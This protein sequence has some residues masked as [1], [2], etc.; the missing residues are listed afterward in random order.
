MK[1]YLFFLLLMLTCSC[2]KDKD[3]RRLTFALDFAGDNRKELEIVLD[4]Y[5]DDSLKLA[6]AKFLIRNMSFYYSFKSTQ[7]ENYKQNL[8]SI[9][10]ENNCSAAEAY[11]IASER[12][13][14][15]SFANF[16]IVYDSH[17]ITADYLIRNIDLAFKVW[18]EVPW[19][20]CI[21][22][23]EFCENILPYRIKD[24][25]LEDWR[26]E[27]YYLYQPLLDSLGAKEDPVKACQVI[28]DHI[29]KQNWVF[30]YDTQLPHLGGLT[31][32]NNRF[33]NCRDRCDLSVYIMRALGISG[34]IDYILQHPDRLHKGHSWNYVKN[35]IGDNVVFELYDL[36]PDSVQDPGSKIKKGIVYRNCFGIQENTLTLVSDKADIPMS[37]SSAFMKDVS[38]L[39]FD[40]VNVV[41]DNLKKKTIVYLAVFNN[42]EWVPVAWNKTEDSKVEFNYLERNIAYI[43]GEYKYSKFIP[44][45]Y[46]FILRENGETEFLKPDILHKQNMILTRKHP[47]PKWWFWFKD[48]T[49]NGKFQGANRCDFKDA[50][51]LYTLTHEATM[52]NYIIEIEEQKKFKYLRY[53]SGINGGCNMAEVNFYTDD[54]EIPIKGKVIGTEG[55]FQNDPQRTKFAMFDGD[56]LTFYDAAEANGAWAGLQLAEPQRVAKIH[57]QFRNDD[58][59][60]RKGDQY[61]LMYWG[62]D[63]IWHTCGKVVA[64]ANKIVYKNIPSGTLYILRNYTRGVEERIFTYDNDRQVWW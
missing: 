9:A 64:T 29:E 47:T 11:K 38:N 2:G 8:Y 57:Y 55:S 36:R 37:L 49:L 63:F 43:A 10:I 42:R 25:P 1:N 20:K 4:H 17:V 18:E 6:A 46:P 44:I 45:S 50:V 22:F 31:L 62:N 27:Y 16:D 26:Q 19:G 52:E 28:F 15:L 53:L 24:E 30:D 7:L 21:L 59:N 14:S 34:G 40:E 58:N 54:S 32:L 39:Y 33:G 35:A 41:I 23:D 56:P 12:Y 3:E 5:K 51:T 13:G 61:E 48:R 60:V